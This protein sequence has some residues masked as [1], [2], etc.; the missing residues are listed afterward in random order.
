MSAIP[1]RLRASL[2]IAPKSMRRTSGAGR[3]GIAR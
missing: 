1:A 2:S 3:G